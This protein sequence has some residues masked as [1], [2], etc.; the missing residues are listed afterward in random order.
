MAQRFKHK[1]FFPDQIDITMA[2]ID[3]LLKIQPEWG[4]ISI[5]KQTAWETGRIIKLITANDG[6]TGISL[7]LKRTKL[8]QKII[9]EYIYTANQGH[10]YSGLAKLFNMKDPHANEIENNFNGTHGGWHYMDRGIGTPFVVFNMESNDKNGYNFSLNAIKAYYMGLQG[11]LPNYLFW[12]LRA[13]YSFHTSPKYP[14]FPIK[15]YE[16]FIP[17]TSF[18]LQVS[19]NVFQNLNFQTEIGYDHGDRLINAIGMGIAVK[20]IIN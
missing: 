4:N 7:H 10:Y 5:Y 15:E 18:G 9:F 19:K 12:K 2:I 1:S 14:G 16:G 20:Y 8:L 13:A 6:I 17:Q 11:Q 3:F